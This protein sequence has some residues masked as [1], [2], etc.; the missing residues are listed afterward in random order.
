MG[1]VLPFGVVFVEL[2]FILSS[3]Y[4]H[5]FYYLF[6]FMA[7]MYTCQK[8]PINEQKRP[9]KE[10]NRPIKEQKRPFRRKRPFKEQKRPMKK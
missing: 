2:F 5:R 10:K 3:I 6:G 4:Q 1:G 8:R 7:G 9:V